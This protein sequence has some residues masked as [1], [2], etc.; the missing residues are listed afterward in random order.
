VPIRLLQSHTQNGVASATIRRLM[1]E[2]SEHLNS[3][4][5]ERTLQTARKLAEDLI[6]K[7]FGVV[8]GMCTG[9]QLDKS[10][11]TQA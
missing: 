2:L 9:S 3:T 1:P 10:V 6:A 5:S 7:G 11:L 8:N 4:T